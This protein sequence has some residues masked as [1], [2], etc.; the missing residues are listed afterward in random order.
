MMLG[1]MTRKFRARLESASYVLQKKLHA[2]ARLSTLVLPLPVAIFT[3]NLRQVSS[4]M[5]LETAPL[6]SKR[7]RSCLSFTPT[8]SFR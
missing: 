7:M 5:P 3:T 4:N 2:S 8:T 6:L 1:A